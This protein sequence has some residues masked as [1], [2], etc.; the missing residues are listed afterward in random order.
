MSE[1]K[2]RFPSLEVELQRCL[3]VEEAL[4]NLSTADLQR[5]V[6]RVHNVDRNEN[7]KHSALA[8]NASSTLKS[9]RVRTDATVPS[10]AR[11]QD[12]ALIRGGTVFDADV[13]HRWKVPGKAFRR[14]SLGSEITEKRSRGTLKA[15]E[16]ELRRRSLQSGGVTRRSSVS[17]EHHRHSITDTV[18]ESIAMSHLSPVAAAGVEL[19]P[20]VVAPAVQTSK[21]SVTAADVVV[22]DVN[23]SIDVPSDRA[24]AAAAA[25][26]PLRSYARHR[27]LVTNC[28]SFARESPL[29][30]VAMAAA[31]GFMTFSLFYVIL[32]GLRR[33]ATEVLYTVVVL[34]WRSG[35]SAMLV[36]C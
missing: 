5:G 25:P 11:P 27:G 31:V 32:F 22:V 21:L 12:N 28:A 16:G 15:V 4:A 18:L 2:W 36:C 8:S 19:H 1:F 9:E 23:D 3:E 34:G 26:A 6:H 24:L 35:P 17:K 29:S 7:Q 14:S 13:R 33:P 10:S 20:A 30:I